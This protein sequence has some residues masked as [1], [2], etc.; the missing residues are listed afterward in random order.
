MLDTYAKTEQNIAHVVPVDDDVEH[1]TIG[2][3]CVC[4]PE[5]KYERHWCGCEDGWIVIHQPLD[6]RA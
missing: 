6:G 4:G 3:G 5:V 2:F 1:K